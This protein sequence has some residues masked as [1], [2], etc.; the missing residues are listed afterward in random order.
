[1]HNE[2]RVDPL[3][4][5]A[6]YDETDN[7]E[8]EDTTV[9]TG[10]AN[11]GAFN[12]LTILK[13]QTSPVGDVATNGTVIYDLRIDNLGTDPASAIVVKDTLPTG[14]QFI[15]AVDT[16]GGPFVNDLFHCVHDGSAFGGVVTCT[17]GDLSGSVNKIDEDPGLPV[18]NVP[19]ERH[20]R[21]KIFAPNTPGTYPN[22]A[23]VDPGNAIPEGNEFDNNSQITTT[24][25]IGGANMFNELSITKNSL[26]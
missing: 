21:V 25:T 8:F 1:M 12:E 18:V 5:I 16:D 15:E 4:E 13:T 26:R 7:I 3:N 6:E 23:V 19:T 10:N 14:S 20:I 9:T 22:S 17:D 11:I 24:V 2:V